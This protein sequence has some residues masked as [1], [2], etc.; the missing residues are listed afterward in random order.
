MD[1]SELVDYSAAAQY[2]HLSPF[3][4]RKWVSEKRIPFVKLGSRVFFTKTQ[5]ASIVSTRAVE[6][7]AR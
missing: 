2:L 3:T 7:V 4:L 1:G 5:L 6:P